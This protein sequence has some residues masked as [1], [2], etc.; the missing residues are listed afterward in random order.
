MKNE[1]KKKTIWLKTNIGNERAWNRNVYSYTRIGNH[2]QQ[3][4]TTTTS[5]IRIRL[6]TRDL[7]VTCVCLLIV[8][9]LIKL[10]E[11]ANI[12]PPKSFHTVKWNRN[13]NRYRLLLRRAL[14]FDGGRGVGIIISVHKTNQRRKKQ[15][16]Q[17][18]QKE[19]KERWNYCSRSRVCVCMCACDTPT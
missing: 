18:S 1:T 9:N 3:Q 15:Q 13:L 14:E 6:V 2:Q 5:N 19:P 4:A 12:N 10:G 11:F 17:R 8:Y 16:Q 7:G